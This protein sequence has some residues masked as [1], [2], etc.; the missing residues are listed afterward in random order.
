MYVELLTAMGI[1]IARSVAGW[2]VKALEDKKVTRFEWKLLASTVIRVS[3]IAG[4]AYFGLDTLGFDIP[5]ISAAAGAFFIDMAYSA[6]KKKK[7]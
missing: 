4:V 7:K 1:P 5:V 6:I 2:A 3:I